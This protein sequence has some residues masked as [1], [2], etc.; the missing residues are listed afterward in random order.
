MG[1][2]YRAALS[3]KFAQQVAV[4][5]IKRGMD[6]DVIVRRFQTEIHVQAAAQEASQY[7]S[8]P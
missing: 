5:L 1:T 6:S 2:V 7:H 3:R 4:K 8:T